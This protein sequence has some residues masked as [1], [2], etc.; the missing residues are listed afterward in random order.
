MRE[1]A[2]C[3]HS[4]DNIT[5]DTEIEDEE[6]WTSALS[7]IQQDVEHA[8]TLSSIAFMDMIVLRHLSFQLGVVQESPTSY[9]VDT[10]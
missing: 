9:R 3:A 1:G 4:F 7:S 8:I 2:L 10:K 6:E 5:R